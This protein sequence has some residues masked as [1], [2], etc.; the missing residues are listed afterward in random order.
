MLSAT[1]D[2]NKLSI[3]P[4]EASISEKYNTSGSSCNVGIYIE[5]FGIP[6]GIFPIIS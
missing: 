6:D 5:K 4:N 3:I 1:T 2:V